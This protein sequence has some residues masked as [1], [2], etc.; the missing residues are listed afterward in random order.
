VLNPS[1]TAG[2]LYSSCSGK[3]DQGL[4]GGTGGGTGNGN[5]PGSAIKL[6][7]GAGGGGGGGGMGCL[8]AT[9]CRSNNFYSKPGVERSAMPCLLPWP[10]NV[11]EIEFYGSFSAFSLNSWMSTSIH[12][13]LLKGTVDTVCVNPTNTFA[14]ISGVHD[15][16][17]YHRQ[18]RTCHQ[19]PN[20]QGSQAVPV[21][22]TGP[23]DY[24][25]PNCVESTSC[26]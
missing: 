4:G 6:N 15:S 12:S 22:L 1:S 19:V 5:G 7:S 24:K 11:G 23:P 3:S 14:G 2:F 13:Q 18:I 16:C 25:Y 26:P 10:N 9:T 20:L 8:D 17:S 21:G